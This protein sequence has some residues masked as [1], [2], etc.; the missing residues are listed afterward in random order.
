VDNFLS[1][2]YAVHTFFSHSTILI[3]NKAQKYR[4]TFGSFFGI[5]YVQSWN[6]AS[7]LFH[8]WD[9]PLSRPQLSASS[10]RLNYDSGTMISRTSTVLIKNKNK[11][12]QHLGSPKLW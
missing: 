9:P 7:Y 10:P 6:T 12:E 11:I 1:S 5:I 3:L 8:L 4:L 2:T